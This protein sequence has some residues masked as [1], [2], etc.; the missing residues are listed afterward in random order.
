M[1]NNDNRHLENRLESDNKEV[2]G[3]SDH[4]AKAPKFPSKGPSKLKVQF[5]KGMTYFLIVAAS[6][7]FYFALLRMTNLSRVFTMVYDVLK[8]IIYG[9][10]LAYLLNP[11]VKKVDKYLLPE[12]EKKIK[13]KE[14]AKGISRGI[15][16]FL[17]LVLLTTL[18]VTLCNLLLPELYA[19]IRNLV[20]TLPGQ[21]NSLMNQINN[22][23]LDDST[24]GALIKAAISEG[25]Q[26]LQ[27]W[28]RTDLLAK[29]NE[30]MSNLTVGVLNILSE[31]FNLLIGVI[32]SVYLLFSKE[33]FSGQSKKAIYALLTPSHA[34]MV[35]HLTTKSN[36]IFG[37]FIIGKIIDSFIIGV[38]CFISLTIL[39]M[40]YVMLVSVIVGV[41]NV[42]P[43]FGPYIGAVPSAIL[44]LLADPVKGI[45]FIIFIILL[46]QFDGNILGPKILG[47]STGLS[48]FWVIFSILLGGGLFGFVG[49][50]MGVPTFAVIYY[51]V[52]MF[53]N[54][55]LEKKRLPANSE[56]YDT[57]SYVDNS[58]NYVH[59]EEEK[60]KESQGEKEEK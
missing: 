45:Y 50:I 57:M 26:M 37:G 27:E 47:D 34:N 22:I 51:I 31:I 20:F 30:I 28:L 38:L 15:G 16:I 9:L 35:L 4:Y 52:Q 7:I 32:V 43:F 2:R 59:S 3:A 13:K 25:T 12:L 23:Q 8:P 21:L 14:R 6:L 10:V 17:G 39:K 29:A 41:T 48:A 33:I 55:R 42:I 24:T 18:I 11:V 1:D 5:G 56:Y 46:Q 54:N 49:M 44:I 40:P 60:E 36:S 53:L 58:G 19:S